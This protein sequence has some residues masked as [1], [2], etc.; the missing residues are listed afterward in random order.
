MHTTLATVLGIPKFEKSRN[1][2]KMEREEEMKAKHA[3]DEKAAAELSSNPEGKPRSGSGGRRKTVA[4]LQ[5]QV[6]FQRLTAK[7]RMTQQRM[8]QLQSTAFLEEEDSGDDDSTGSRP[9]TP[10]PPSP[11]RPRS[12]STKDYDMFLVGLAAAPPADMF[13]YL[14]SIDRQE[15]DT[16]HVTHA[17][18]VPDEDTIESL[19]NVHFE[20]A[21]LYGQGRFDDEEDPSFVK[22][23]ESACFHLCYA[24]AYGCDK[25]TV[26]VG[27]MLLGLSVGE[28]CEGLRFCLEDGRALA[29]KALGRAGGDAVAASLLLK[30]C[31]EGECVE[32]VK[33]L[34]EV[35]IDYLTGGGAIAVAVVVGDAVEA[36]YGGGE[37]YYKG[38]VREVNGGQVRVYYPDDDEEEWLPVKFV[39]KEVEVA[40]KFKV[41]E[42]VEA[43]FGGGETWYDAEVRSVDGV[44]VTVFYIEDQEEETVVEKFVRSKGGSEQIEEEKE[45]LEV[46]LW[47]VY[48]KLG[49]AL[50][51]GEEEGKGEARK[52]WGLAGDEAIKAGKAK[53]GMALKMKA[54][55]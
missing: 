30:Y 52:Y 47:E 55:A 41:G 37:S 22:D 15:A 29:R 1:E 24:S 42:V 25:A 44:N 53:A 50:A 49:T 9:T 13:S 6:K 43:A 36:A 54:E 40:S 3:E 35:C 11:R 2:M 45:R 17:A 26:A 28:I 32:E 18:I 46:A 27:K 8:T 33:K 20:I 51:G 48:D 38:E 39:R 23:T 12:Q 31:C 7:K 16:R 19:G 4:M 21:V 5:D 10:T 34:C 14:K